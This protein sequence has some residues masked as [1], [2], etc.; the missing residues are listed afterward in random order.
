MDPARIHEANLQHYF[1]SIYFFR[2]TPTASGPNSFG[3]SRMGFCDRRKELEREI[4]KKIEDEEQDAQ[5]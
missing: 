2:N 5:S 3:K 1:F 4:M